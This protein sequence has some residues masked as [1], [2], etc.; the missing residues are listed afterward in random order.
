MSSK[1]RVGVIALGLVLGV[2][3]LPSLL[4]LLVADQLPQALPSRFAVNGKV[5]AIA[6]RHLDLAALKWGPDLQETVTVGAVR[7]VY[8][9]P[10]LWRKRVDGLIV[11]GLTIH[12]V[13]GKD[14]LRLRGFVPSSGPGDPPAPNKR[15]WRL[16]VG[17]GRLV[18]RQGLVVIHGQGAASAVPF[19]LQLETVAGQP[20]RLE[21]VLDLLPELQG[22]TVKGEIDLAART[23]LAA[24]ACH[25]PLPAVTQFWPALAGQGLTGELN[26]DAQ[27]RLGDEGGAVRG[28]WSSVLVPPAKGARWLAE[29]AST[30]GEFSA[31]LAP[32]DGG[33]RLAATGVVGGEAARDLTINAPGGRLRSGPLH[34]ECQGQGQAKEGK[35]DLQ[36]AT[37][38]IAMEEVG[39]ELGGLTVKLPWQWPVPVTGVASATGTTSVSQIKVQGKKLGG[40]DLAWQQEG[41]LGYRFK[42]AVHSGGVSKYALELEGGIDLA[43]EG[44]EPEFTLEASLPGL[45]LAGIS[46]SEFID[47]DET[48]ELGGTLMAKAML[49]RAGGPLEARAEL[50]ISDGRLAIANKEVEISGIKGGVHFPDLLARHSDSA[51]IGFQQAKVG[52]VALTEGRVTFHLDQ[53]HSLFFEKA[54]AGWNDGTVQAM[55]LSLSPGKRQ[56]RVDLY[57]DRLNLAKTFA[58][59]GVKQLSG[60]GAVNGRLPLVYEDGKFSISQ[61]FLYSTPGGGGEIRM[62]AHDLITAGVPAGSPQAGQLEFASAALQD[63]IYNWLTIGLDTEDDTL[64]VTMKLDGRPAHALPFR[65]DEG[66]GAFTRLTAAGEV[67]MNQPIRL[68]VNFR[69]PLND[70]LGY[71]KGI[72][73]LWDKRQ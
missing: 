6:W 45:K 22:A 35:L 27:L 38:R 70:L 43:P 20:A 18:I 57:C 64:V 19:E 61:G 60:Q 51:V 59:L 40:L 73:S 33:W 2:A 34:L 63:F 55:A 24:I 66:L 4:T 8:S 32:D 69:L 10:G 53:G 17:L 30:S 52:A 7:A 26:V 13:N 16:P 36:L 42:G 62:A 47:L 49:R 31:A 65:Y 72:K 9:V 68:D 28:T 48:I 14:G 21:F 15:D 1:A 58:Q 50:A 11:S 37:E 5:R 23:A 25:L 44:Q 56:A 3:L 41:L 54:E 12:L 46:P 29:A 67:G 39:L 71:G